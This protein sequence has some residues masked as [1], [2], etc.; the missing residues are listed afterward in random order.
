VTVTVALPVPVRERGL[1]EVRVRVRCADGS[2]GLRSASV[3][4]GVRR[5][6]GGG[7][8]GYSASMAHDTVPASHRDLL[9]G[10]FATLATVGEDGFPHVSEVWFLAEDDQVAISLNTA[11]QKTKNL[12]AEPACTVFL[13][14]LANPYRY[15]EIRGN[16]DITPDEDLAFADKVGAKYGADVRA[17]DGPDDTRVVVRIVPVRV[18][19][20]DMSG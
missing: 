2:G 14:D 20:V 3:D 4:R 19:A 6:L 10:R 1:V 12:R 16:A 5:A 18:N 17:H 15:L 7:Q 13:L 9:D 8:L 11:R